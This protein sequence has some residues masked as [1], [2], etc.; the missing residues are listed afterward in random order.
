M[1]NRTFISRL[2]FKLTITVPNV[3]PAVRILK[4]NWKYIYFTHQNLPTS[5]GE[6]IAHVL[7]FVVLYVMTAQICTLLILVSLAI[8]K[9]YFQMGNLLKQILT[10]K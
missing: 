1:V 10:L 7:L 4:V 8:N 9:A 5:L 2:F 3:Q 6:C